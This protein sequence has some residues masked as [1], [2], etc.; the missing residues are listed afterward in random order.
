MGI[1]CCL[2]SLCLQMTS[3][4]EWKMRCLR[5]IMALEGAP[6]STMSSLFHPV[7]T[8]QC[9]C[10]LSWGSSALPDS[11]TPR[12][13]SVLLLLAGKC[14]SQPETQPRPVGASPSFRCFPACGGAWAQPQHLILSMLTSCGSAAIS[15]L[16]HMSAG[17]S[18][19]EIYSSCSVSR[20]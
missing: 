13:P 10:C 9:F 4:N 12:P 5:D 14:Q 3:G 16:L 17:S 11:A 20:L 6:A 18:I 2:T 1:C 19:L 7:C 15:C 8:L